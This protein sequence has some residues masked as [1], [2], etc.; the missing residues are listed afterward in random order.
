LKESIVLLAAIAAVTRF[1]ALLA[2]A[3]STATNTDWSLII[4]AGT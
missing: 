2:L 3:Q 1:V 4:F